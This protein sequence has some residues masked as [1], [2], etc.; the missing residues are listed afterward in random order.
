MSL[1]FTVNSQTAKEYPQ[2]TQEAVRTCSLVTNG[3]QPPVV[4][5]TLLIPV[6]ACFYYHFV[7]MCR[8]GLGKSGSGGQLTP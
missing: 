7:H 2:F 8:H 3:F 5:L 4:R 1:K 6:S